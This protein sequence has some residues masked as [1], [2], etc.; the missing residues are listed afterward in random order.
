MRMSRYSQHASDAARLLTRNKHSVSVAESS[1]G[2]LIAANLLSVPGASDYFVGGTVIYTRKSRREF[3]DLDRERIKKL[4]PLT[5]EMAFE[6]AAAARTKLDTTWGIAELGVAGPG[7][8]P[9]SD[10][11]GISVI[12][13]SGPIDAAVTIKTQST[14]RENNMEIFADAALQLLV[15]T[16]T[17][18]E[19][20]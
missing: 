17:K 5:E 18:I 16:L 11:V 9:Y 14:D 6:F 20:D 1:T 13:I 10:A 3:L 15:K 4:K 19:S 2:G 12:A 7:S 8:T